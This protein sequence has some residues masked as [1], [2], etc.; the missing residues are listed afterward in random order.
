VTLVVL[1]P[2]PKIAE[3]MNSPNLCPLCCRMDAR[4]G[5]IGIIVTQ[6][7]VD[8]TGNRIAPYVV[9]APSFKISILSMAASGIELRSTNIT[10]T[11]P[12]LL[13]VG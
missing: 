4:F 11:R 13:P 12:G 6:L 1:L 3:V 10:L 8:Y 5:A 2:T 7:D 9:D